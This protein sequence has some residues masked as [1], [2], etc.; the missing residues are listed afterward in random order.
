M[1][2]DDLSARLPDVM[3]PAALLLCGVCAWLWWPRTDRLLV[4]ARL[5]AI[6]VLVAV[7]AATA[8]VGDA[9]QQLDRASMYGGLLRLPERVAERALELSER[10]PPGQVPSATAS[11]LLPFFAYADRCLGGED[12]ILVPDFLP[13]IAVWAR[14]PFAGGQVVFQAGLLATA[15]DHRRVM[16]RLARERVPVAVYRPARL[17]E[18]VH[19]FP[20][21][22]TY[23]ERFSRTH[24]FE[25]GGH[26]PVVVRFDPLFVR[27]HDAE[28]GW[29]CYR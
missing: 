28:T 26:V 19:D 1:L 13:E 18:V 11:A 15:A 24:A 7:F 10:L 2:R 29:P 4:P 9:H 8:S 22:A 12:R 21:L 14:R 6:A 3:A 27:G 5:A 16:S 23:V 20:E 25:P 17:D